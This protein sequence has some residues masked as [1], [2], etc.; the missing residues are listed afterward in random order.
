MLIIYKTS[1]DGLTRVNGGTV[2]KQTRTGLRKEQK[3]NE[4][5]KVTSAVI[6]FDH[7]MVCGFFF[8]TKILY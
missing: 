6:R 8:L 7:F 4:Q 2:E 3:N 5:I 1:T